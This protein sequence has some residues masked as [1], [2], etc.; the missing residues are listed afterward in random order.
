M[1]QLPSL[2]AAGR[3]LRKTYLFLTRRALGLDVLVVASLASLIA[4]AVLKVI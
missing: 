4:M 3:Q 1:E 2:E